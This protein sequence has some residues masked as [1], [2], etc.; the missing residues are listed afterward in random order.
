[1]G[2]HAARQKLYASIGL[3]K[4]GFEHQRQTGK[5]GSNSLLGRVIGRDRLQGRRR[6]RRKS[7]VAIRPHVGGGSKRDPRGR[8]QQNYSTPD[9][10]LCQQGRPDA[11]FVKTSFAKTIFFPVYFS[12]AYLFHAALRF[13]RS[14]ERNRNGARSALSRAGEAARGLLVI[15]TGGKN[16]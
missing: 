12:H 11:I 13:N 5:D 3:A 8:E 14:E 7:S 10:E 9:W 1:M 2:T 4:V 6:Y 15:K 16:K